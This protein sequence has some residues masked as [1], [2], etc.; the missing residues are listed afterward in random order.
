M[1]LSTKEKAVAILMLYAA[2]NIDP[3]FAIQACIEVGIDKKTVIQSV[4][5]LEKFR[6]ELGA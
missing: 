4:K 5:D 2:K 6:L 1:S 3:S